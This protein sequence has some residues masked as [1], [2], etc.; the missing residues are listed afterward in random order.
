MLLL[1]LVFRLPIHKLNYFKNLLAYEKLFSTFA[2]I[3]IYNCIDN[4][5]SYFR[6]QLQAIAHKFYFNFK[7]YKNRCPIFTKHEYA[8]LKE[9][10]YDTS[11]YVTKPDKGYGIVILNKQG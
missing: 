8:I 1:G 9:L 5:K 10:S 6:S 4:A 3:Q 7:A 2:N 11:I